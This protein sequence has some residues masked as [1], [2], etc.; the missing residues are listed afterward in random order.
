DDLGV[1]VHSLEEDHLIVDHASGI[2]KP[3]ACFIGLPSALFGMIKMRMYE[4]RV[5]A[6]EDAAK[7]VG[8]PL[9]QGDEVSCAQAKDLHMFDRPQPG[10]DVIQPGIRI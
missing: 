2:G 3:G 1:I 6:L 5:I 10:K 4:H 7:L 8:H 9:W